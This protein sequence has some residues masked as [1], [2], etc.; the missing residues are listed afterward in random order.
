MKWKIR[1][2]NSHR[3]NQHQACRTKW[4]RELKWRVSFQKSFVSNFNEVTTSRMVS[5]LLAVAV[6]SSTVAI[7]VAL[8]QSP[9]RFYARFAV[10]SVVII[11]FMAHAT[12]RLFASTIVLIENIRTKMIS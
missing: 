3:A 11:C 10:N 7:S 2:V 4:N 12:S 6:A 1:N 5:M 8:H 9:E